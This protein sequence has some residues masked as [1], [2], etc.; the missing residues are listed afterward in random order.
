MLLVVLCVLKSA[1]R[2]ENIVREF[3][4]V[5]TLHV[6]DVSPRNHFRGLV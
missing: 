1:V 2:R 3:S 4:L 5:P 6:R